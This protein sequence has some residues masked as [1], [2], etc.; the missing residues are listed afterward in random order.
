MGDLEALSTAYEKRQDTTNVRK[1]SQEIERIAEEFTDAQNRTQDY[2]DSRKDEL[3][4]IASDTSQKVRQAQEEMVKVKKKAKQVEASILKEEAIQSEKRKEEEEYAKKAGTPKRYREICRHSGYHSRQ[5]EGRRYEELGNGSLYAKLQKKMTEQMLA[6]YHRWVY[7]RNK[8]ECVETLQEWVIQEAE[9]RTIATETL[10]G[11]SRSSSG[12]QRKDQTY[13]GQPRQQSS[14]RCQQRDRNRACKV[15]GEGHPVWLCNKFKEMTVP[16]R[17]ETAKQHSLCYRCLGANHVG[18]SCTRSRICGL[19][20][21]IDTHNRLLHEAKRRESDKEKSTS[22]QKANDNPEAKQGAQGPTTEG[23]QQRSERSLTTTV[24]AKENVKEEYIVLRT[25]PVILK[26][27]GR[28]LVV[29]A[30][31]DDASSK[32]YVN[33][34]VPAELGLQGESRKVT[35]NFLNGQ[36]D[37]FETMPVECE[38]ESLD[39]RISMRITAFT[40][41]RVT[42]NMKAVNW[43]RYAKNWN[44]LKDINFP[45]LRPRPIVD[46]LIG[47]DYAD[48][49]YSIKDV[50]GR[51]GKPV[52]RLTPLGWTCIG[53]PSL[54]LEQNYRTN[55]ICTHSVYQDSSVELGN[56]ILKFWEIEDGGLQ[57]KT[58]TLKPED[59]VALEALK[60]TIKFEDG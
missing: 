25:V 33:S 54:C 19:N 52:A 35:V 17:W 46:I 32:T 49:H 57:V 47:I 30:L 18:Q 7:E 48:L 44:H 45:Y 60:K 21:C 10:R 13:F 39:G 2:L 41:N 56:A 23:R 1:L 22:G 8:T 27:G 50:R 43:A 3:S 24:H 20:G 5:P 31:L 14:P 34:D 58:K 4:S 36:E 55:F 11:V 29:N 53:H 26:S 42:G 40:A 9:F 38:I 15:C 37:T 16:E 59:K 51:P 28:K 12:M 6:Q